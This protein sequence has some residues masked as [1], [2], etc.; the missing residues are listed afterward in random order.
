[1]VLLTLFPPLLE[2]IAAGL[3]ANWWLG[4]PIHLAW[5]LGAVLGAVSP[6]V[7]VP[8]LMNLQVRRYGIKKGIPLTLLAASSFNDVFNITLFSVTATIAYNKAGT[9]DETVGAVLLKILLE[10]IGG[11]VVG[12]VLGLLM[13]FI[14]NTGHVF[15]AIV[16]LF[17]T[18]LFVVLSEVFKV[19]EAKYIGIIT[20]GYICFRWWGVSGKPEHLLAEIW[21]LFTPFLFGT[22]GAALKFDEIDG[23]VILPGIF[24]VVLGIVTR[25]LTTIG[26]MKLTGKYNL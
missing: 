22:I 3:L 26:S 4:M 23:G 19:P 9:S 20:Y 18:A 11:I 10:I 21:V 24:I 7:L 16:T 25:G 6:A 13:K 12:I 14:T 15:K 1:M 5:C 8:C 17:V 2:G